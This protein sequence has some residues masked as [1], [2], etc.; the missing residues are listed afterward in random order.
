[1][2]EPDSDDDLLRPREAAEML[3]VPSA[4]IGFWARTGVL[5]A[6]V[7]TPGGQR[8]YRR[9]DLRV[10]GEAQASPRQKEMEADAVR[11]YEQGWPIRRVAAQF[12]C[13]YSRM[14]RILLKHTRL[15][16]R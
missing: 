3:G 12:G 13:G 1:V 8:R 5:K 6:A 4:T 15:R 14:R 11:L 7:R 2:S 16:T 9:A 10:F